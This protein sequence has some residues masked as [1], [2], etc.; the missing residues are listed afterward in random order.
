MGGGL[1]PVLTSIRRA[2]MFRSMLRFITDFGD[3]AYLLPAAALVLGY[4]VYSKARSS[5]VA[6][7]VAFAACVGLT[8][9]LKISFLTCG[10]KVGSLDIYS[11]SGH[12]SFATTFYLCVG[13][14]TSRNKAP[15]LAVIVF[16]AAVCLAVAIAASRLL[17]DAHTPGEVA[18]GL[19]IGVGCVIWFATQYYG[20]PQP[21]LP[22]LPVL[23]LLVPLA[24]FAHGHH[25]SRESWFNTAAAYIR[26]HL[27]ICL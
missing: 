24:L 12:T 11:P 16:A 8:A 13:L 23:A 20:V 27:G 10:A 14:V 15:L 17:L 18:I 26:A 1:V 7:A 25:L 5:A 2:A 19:L 3:A 6:W 21:G 4:L 22:I 9:L